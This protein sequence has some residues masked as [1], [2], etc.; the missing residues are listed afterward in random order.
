MCLAALDS[1]QKAGALNGGLF[2]EWCPSG[3]Y[4]RNGVPVTRVRESV[5]EGWRGSALVLPQG[6]DLFS[7]LCLS[8]DSEP[9]ACR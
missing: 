7:H 5:Q 9:H 3:P 8:Q 1:H 2:L 6:K 4:S